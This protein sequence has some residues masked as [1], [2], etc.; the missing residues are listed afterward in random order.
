MYLR[1]SKRP[2][3]LCTDRVLGN[4]QWQDNRSGREAYRRMMQKRTL[5]VFLSDHPQ[6]FDKQ[7]DA[8]RRGWCLGDSDFRE[9]MEKRVDQ[10]IRDYDRRSYLGEAANRHDE[11]EATRLLEFG[12]D[13]FGL[14]SAELDGLKKNDI[15]KK[16]VAWL[17]RQHTGVRNDWIC[18]HLV[19]GRASNLARHVNDMRSG[20]DPEIQEL[21]KMMK[22]AF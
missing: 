7:W 11:A 12:L 3:W 4:Y 16:A 15:R 6:E 2:E 1:P 5:E 13:A 21:R 9:E 22:K 18:E 19:M 14:T 8:I 20:D 10:R 17:I